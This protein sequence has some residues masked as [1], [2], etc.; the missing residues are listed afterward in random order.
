M[1]LKKLLLGKKLTVVTR[2]DSSDYHHKVNDDSDLNYLISLAK[3]SNENVQGEV[4][5]SPENLRRK[6]REVRRTL[7]GS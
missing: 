2:K 6:P 1:G 3:R 5:C 7:Q 4:W